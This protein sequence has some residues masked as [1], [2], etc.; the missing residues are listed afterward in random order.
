[1]KYLYFDLDETLFTT[2]DRYSSLSLPQQDSLD[3]SVDYEFFPDQKSYPLYRSRHGLIFSHLALSPDDFRVY[4]LT[5]AVYVDARIR[6]G[7]A[8][9]FGNRDFFW[10]VPCINRFHYPNA[11][12]KGEKILLHMRGLEQ[13]NDQGGLSGLEVWLID[14]QPGNRLSAIAVGA[15]AIASDAADYITKLE[16]L[17]LGGPVELPAKP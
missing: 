8:K 7:L 5:S 9:F 12:N 4:V 13:A 14:D 15:K 10:N 17:V 1:M 3:N 11:Q 6:K 16:Q 2:L